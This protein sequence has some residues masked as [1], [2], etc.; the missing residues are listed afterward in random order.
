MVKKALNFLI[1]ILSL[2][3]IILLFIFLFKNA[4]SFGYE[5]FSDQAK[6]QEESLNVVESSIHISEGES[7]L[8]IG[9][10]LEAKRIIENKWVFA[11]S[12]RFM[13]GYDR[14]KEGDYIVKSTQKPSEILKLLINEEE[15]K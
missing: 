9:T 7:L 5:V 1:K 15:E 10:A 12:V 13:E 4:R 2:I 3:L 14:I 11:I 6:D 8:K